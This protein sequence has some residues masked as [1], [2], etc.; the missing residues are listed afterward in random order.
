MN[1]RPALVLLLALATGGALYGRPSHHYEYVGPNS[2][3]WYEPGNWS[4][5]PGGGNLGPHAFLRP[6]WFH[7]HKHHGPSGAAPDPAVRA[8]LD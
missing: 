2:G 7:G 8:F 1:L 4:P 5:T 6:A 3:S